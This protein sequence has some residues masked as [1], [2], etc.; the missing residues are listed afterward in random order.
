[1][2]LKSEEHIINNKVS[3]LILNKHSIFKINKY[4]DNKDEYY[5][6]FYDKSDRNKT[7]YEYQNDIVIIFFPI[8]KNIFKDFK[9]SFFHCIS[10]LYNILFRYLDASWENL[11]NGLRLFRRDIKVVLPFFSNNHFSYQFTKNF[12]DVQ[13]I[14]LIKNF[15][16]FYKFKNILNLEYLNHSINPI[17]YRKIVIFVNRYLFINIYKRLNLKIKKYDK[18]LIHRNNKNTIV[19]NDRCFENYDECVQLIKKKHP[20]IL[21]FDPSNY[22]L[23]EQ[24]Y[25]MNNC[26]LLICD[27]GSSL[28]NML[29]MKQFESD[30][31]NRKKCKCICI[32]HPWMCYFQ[33]R[34]EFTIFG[35]RSNIWKEID[36]IRIY[37]NIFYKNKILTRYDRN[38]KKQ[39][40]SIYINKFEG[41]VKD[42]NNKNNNDYKYVIRIKDLR[43]ELRNIK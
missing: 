43:V 19:E 36:F 28:T 10:M 21:I 38:L 24:I 14:I 31:V 23:I 41:N 7:N 35:K 27:W 6:D 2:K 40:K 29:W 11:F 32:I 26:K 4:K 5:L 1:M 16:F 22:S 34:N 37:T 12:V 13:N 18:I 33:N 20:D 15:D 17:H 25:L 8:T 39:V 42:E 30:D 3:N 9:L